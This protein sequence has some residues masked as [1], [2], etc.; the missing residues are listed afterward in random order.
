M[1]TPKA[2]V[3][4]RDGT[5]FDAPEHYVLKDGESIVSVFMASDAQ[6]KAD[7]EA[8]RIKAE[9][10]L[11]RKKAEDSSAS[12]AVGRYLSLVAAMHANGGAERIRRLCDAWR[13]Q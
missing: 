4:R 1:A 12:D 5:L 8:G 10:L 9:A 2:L 11:G 6:A 3:R 13:Q 7:F